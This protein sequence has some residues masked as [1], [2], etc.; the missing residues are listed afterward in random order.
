MTGSSPAHELRSAAGGSRAH[1]ENR[2][3][4]R[5]ASSVSGSG[6]SCCSSGNSSL[7]LQRDWFASSGIQQ[8]L[9]STYSGGDKSP[10]ASTQS[11]SK[12]EREQLQL[13]SIIRGPCV[14]V[15]T[16]AE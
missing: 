15:M 5:E 10:W 4:S 3:H 13:A 7:T 14:N 11:R 6:C 1:L 8:Q 16:Q 9:A 12:F 2:W